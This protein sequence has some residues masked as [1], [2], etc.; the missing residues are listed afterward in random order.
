MTVVN[1]VAP[2]PGDRRMLK[3][4][5][6]T[7]ARSAESWSMGGWLPN[8]DPVLKAMG[9]D[10]SVY[11][12]LTADAHVAGC[13]RRR[14]AAVQDLEYGLEREKAPARLFRSIE[15][16]LADLDL[17]KLVR[18]AMDGAFYGYQPMEVTWGRV[19]GLLLPVEVTAKPQE[20][21]F[22]T[23]ENELRF[24][25]KGSGLEGEELPPRKFVVARQG[26]SYQNPYGQPDLAPCFWPVTFKRGGLRFW[27]VFTEKYGSPFLVG[28]APRSATDSEVTKLLDSLAEMV[29]DAVAVIPDDSSVDIQEAA[30][31]ANSADV[32]QQFM[33]FCR[34]EVSIALL[35]SNQSTEMDSNRASS[36]SGLQIADD[37]AMGDAEM[38]GEVVNELI[39]WAA[40]YNWP[41]SPRPLW[42]LRPQEQI[43]DLRPK[44]DEIL[45][46]SGVRFSR[47]YWMRTYGLEEDDL[48]PEEPEQPAAP[49]PPQ[50]APE[51]PQE[52]EQPQSEEDGEDESQAAEM[53]DG[54]VPVTTQGD[55]LI[56]EEELRFLAE[57]WGRLTAQA[58]LDDA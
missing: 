30:G 52:D 31:K 41:G 40:E 55:P 47:A 45:V 20:W 10:I 42:S 11:R 49:Q 33:L 4:D 58:D 54:G 50:L 56:G 44:R 29:Q 43:D 38:I 25:A 16:W 34:S 9:R 48:E 32:Y 3:T 37:L 12:D 53:A 57:T 51:Q 23:P 24:R 6:A 35:G 36:V 2:K 22:Y 39:G 8:P 15:S 46:R 5:I 19:G 28:K 17:E 26:P 13:I 21:F 7:R 27:A 1:Y 18:E 14:R